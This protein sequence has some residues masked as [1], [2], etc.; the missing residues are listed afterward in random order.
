LGKARSLP[1]ELSLTSNSSFAGSS[2]VSI[3]YTRAEVT[4]PKTPDNYN[5]EI[6]KAINCSIVNA[7]V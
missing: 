2:L 1:V 3:Y 5:T 7:P 6:I 4:D